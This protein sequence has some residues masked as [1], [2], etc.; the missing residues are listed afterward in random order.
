MAIS[1]DLACWYICCV[2]FLPPVSS[3]MRTTCAVTSLCY[4]RRRQREERNERDG[5]RR[6]GDGGR[7][8]GDGGRRKGG[9]RKEGGR[10]EGG[11]REE[12]GRREGGGRE[13]AVTKEEETKIRL[14]RGYLDS[15][16]LI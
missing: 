16:Y 4:G 5:G 3:C 8:E 13:R 2:L 9:G 10:R 12:G 6:E 14:N 1:L 7:R 15:V 11:G